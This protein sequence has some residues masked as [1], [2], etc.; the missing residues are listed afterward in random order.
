MY[1]LG[2]LEFF[3]VLGQVATIIGNVAISYTKPNIF[4]K[5]VDG[6]N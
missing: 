3:R 5:K 1:F 4:Y 6:I 2:F